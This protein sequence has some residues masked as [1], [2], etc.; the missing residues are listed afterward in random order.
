MDVVSEGG[1]IESVM[2]VEVTHVD[3]NRVVV[4]Q[5]TNTTEQEST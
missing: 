3:G 4:R 1:M 5:I 2:P